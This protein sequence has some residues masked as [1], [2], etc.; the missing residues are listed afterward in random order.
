[1]KAIDSSALI[2]YFSREE[3][4]DRVEGLILEGV[5]SL[6]LSIKE[7]ANALCKK[8]SNKEIEA[9]N[10]EE[11]VRDLTQS[12][13]IKIK[14]QNDYILGAFK[15]AIKNRTTIYD[16][17]FIELA[18]SDSNELVTSDNTQ[19][20]IAEKEGVKTQIV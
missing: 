17:L 5:V 13:A 3:G 15:I 8:V 19:A 1:M 11:I 9:R 12:E 14:S 6:D 4:W 18:K 20:E 10:A 16:S 7:T 2:K